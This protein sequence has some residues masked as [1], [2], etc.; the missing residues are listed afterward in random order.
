MR[1]CRMCISTMWRSS[2][3]VRVC[4][5][6]RFIWWLVTLNYGCPRKGQRGLHQIIFISTGQSLLIQN[7]VPDILCQKVRID[8]K[9]DITV[10]WFIERYQ[11]ITHIA[12]L[13]VKSIKIIKT[14]SFS[15]ERWYLFVL[16]LWGL[17]VH[18]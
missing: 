7:K 4:H 5:L 13:K 3:R 18:F 9:F 14:K 6:I 1:C 8:S 16:Q 11:S 12:T 17:V 2:M 15:N 10:F